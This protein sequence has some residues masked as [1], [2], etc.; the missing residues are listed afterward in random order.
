MK[1]KGLGPW[2]EPDNQGIDSEMLLAFHAHL[3]S[4]DLRMT[5]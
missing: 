1:M 3:N 4:K 2:G 5:A